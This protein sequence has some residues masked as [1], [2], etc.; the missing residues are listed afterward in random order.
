MLLSDKENC[1]CFHEDASGSGF[2]SQ[3]PCHYGIAPHL[4]LCISNYIITLSPKC[5][6]VIYF[7]RRSQVSSLQKWKTCHQ[8]GIQAYFF[9]PQSFW[10]KKK[11]YWISFLTRPPHLRATML[12]PSKQNTLQPLQRQ[13]CCLTRLSAPSVKPNTWNPGMLCNCRVHESASDYV[14]ALFTKHL[15]KSS[16]GNYISFLLNMSHKRREREKS[17]ERERECECVFVFLMGTTGL[18]IDEAEPQIH[19]VHW[20][21]VRQRS[22]ADSCPNSKCRVCW[23]SVQ[24]EPHQWAAETDMNDYDSAQSKQAS[25]MCLFWLGGCRLAEARGDKGR[26]NLHKIFRAEHG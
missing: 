11:K 24:S 7:K 16:K 1:P 13:V 9:W 21:G 17:E 12:V 5:K 26:G 23:R 10:E 14:N 15:E 3:D 8:L 6:R 18:N 19:C 4:Q 22:L 20:T 2:H 25:K